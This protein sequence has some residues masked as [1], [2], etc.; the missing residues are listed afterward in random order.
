MARIV[1]FK[2]TGLQGD[3]RDFFGAINN[4]NDYGFN[5][6]V[7]SLVVMEG[8]WELFQNSDFKGDRYVVTFRNGVADTNAYPS[9]KYWGGPNDN[10]S[11]LRPLAT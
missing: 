1:L 2:D 6:V 4:L 7:S 11:S 10:L 5:D 8:D 9:Y 3:S